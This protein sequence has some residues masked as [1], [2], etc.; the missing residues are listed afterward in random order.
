MGIKISPKRIMQMKTTVRANKMLI[1]DLLFMILRWFI[2]MW[3]IT[4]STAL[5]LRAVWKRRGIYKF[6]PFQS[7]RGYKAIRH[8]RN[9]KRKGVHKIAKAMAVNKSRNKR[10]KKDKKR[11][12]KYSL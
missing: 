12:R 1:M 8:H 2:G 7:K 6:M 5:N 4:K 3:S 11:G 10:H 9:W